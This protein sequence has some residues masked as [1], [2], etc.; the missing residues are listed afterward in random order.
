MARPRCGPGAVD[1]HRRAADAPRQPRAFAPRRPPARVGDRAGVL[2]R[3][4]ARHGHSRL[5]RRNHLGARRSASAGARLPARRL[6]DEDSA[7]FIFKHTLLRDVTSTVLLRDRRRLHTLAAEWL[8]DHSG[9]RRNEFLEQI[10]GHLQLA[11][12]AA[13][14]AELHV[15]ASR[16]VIDAGRSSSAKRS[17][18]AAFGSWEEA[19]VPPPVDAVLL[20]GRA[21]CQTGDLEGG[22][23]ALSPLLASDVRG[24]PSRP[25]TRPR[26]CTSRAG[27]RQSAP[28][29]RR[30]ERC[31]TRPCP[32][33]S[34]SVA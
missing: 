10:A 16:R 19:A 33:P 8:S 24:R 11:G 5:A 15:A 2:G 27:S 34:R 13:D 29:T 9:E 26:P 7:E 31:S 4:R 28:I 17:L 30:S 32:S 6:G 1:A 18:E 20:Y 12:R 21:C 22:A 14:A 25:S 23:R 3:R